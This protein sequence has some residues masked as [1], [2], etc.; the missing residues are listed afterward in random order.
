MNALAIDC[1]VSKLCIA[2]KKRK[3]N[4]KTLPGHRNKAVGKDSSGN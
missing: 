1:A 3:S 4:G 2:A